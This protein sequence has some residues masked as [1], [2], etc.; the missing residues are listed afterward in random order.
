MPTPTIL[1]RRYP[2]CTQRSTTAPLS[3]SPAIASPPP[4]SSTTPL[5]DGWKGSVASW[6]RST[7]ERRDARCER[8]KGVGCEDLLRLDS[9]CNDHGFFFASSSSSGA[10]VG[11]GGVI[12]ERLRLRYHASR[13]CLQFTKEFKAKRPFLS[14]FQSGVYVT[15]ATLFPSF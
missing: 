5:T 11:F 10:W 14:I 4:P 15:P 12:R 8:E 3:I 6:M 13:V 1:E 7:G 9:E 2:V